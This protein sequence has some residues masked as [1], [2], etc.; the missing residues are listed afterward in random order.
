MQD[1]TTLLITAEQVALLDEYS[2]LARFLQPAMV[3]IEDADLI[4]RARVS[5]RSP[6][7]ESP[8]N[9]LLNEMD[10][11]REDATPET[12]GESL[13]STCTLSTAGPNTHS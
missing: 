7:E 11:L 4:A 12:S 8:L 3:V 10:G 9:R 5:M 6:C 1:H 13:G 2:Q